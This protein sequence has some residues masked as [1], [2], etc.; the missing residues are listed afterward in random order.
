MS[1]HAR[2][3]IVKGPQS[4]ISLSKIKPE[5][6]SA[7]SR[8]NARRLIGPKARATR[9]WSREF[10]KQTTGIARTIGERRP[11][12]AHRTC[13]E[14]LTPPL[15]AA[16]S[17]RH[18]SATK[19]GGRSTRATA[20]K[21]EGRSGWGHND[22]RSLGSHSCD[23]G[24]HQALAIKFNAVSGKF[25]AVLIRRTMLCIWRSALVAI[26]YNYAPNIS[27]A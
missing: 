13:G 18:N 21:R 10:D 9:R 17:W 3:G 12:G 8:R 19:K 25:M 23:S 14:A 1:R 22:R 16:L 27:E 11:S 4:R 6:R 2:R 5:V 7:H 24:L 26:R 15:S 20:H